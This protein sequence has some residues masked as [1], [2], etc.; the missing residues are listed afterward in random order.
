MILF[1]KLLE[2]SCHMFFK[3]ATN[4]YYEI[5][6]LKQRFYQFYC[7][8]NAKTHQTRYI[9]QSIIMFSFLFK[10]RLHQIIS[11]QIEVSTHSDCVGNCRSYLSHTYLISAEGEN[12]AQ[13]YP[14]KRPYAQ[15]TGLLQI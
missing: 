6:K 14:Y 3:T 4:L 1:L 9:L 12:S 15:E 7:H 8:F 10:K 2:L 13:F 11:R 5:L